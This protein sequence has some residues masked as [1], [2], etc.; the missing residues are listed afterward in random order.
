[1]TRRLGRALAALVV[2][3]SLASCSR[4]GFRSA[5]ASGHP[6]RLVV[7]NGLGDPNS[8]NI[9]LDPG[10]T[11]GDISELTQ[12][13][14]VRYDVHAHPV[15]ELATIVPTQRNHGISADGKTITWHLR[16]G[17]RWSDGAPFSGDDVIFSVHAIM[18]PA[19]NEEQGT[20]GWDLIQKMDEPDPY[21]VVFHLK[22]P[23]GS[24]VPLY[25]GTAANEPCILPK[26][27]LGGLHDINTAPYNSK[28]VGTGPFRVVE[29]RRG[30]A[31]ELEANPY[32][33]RG[34]P[35]L[36]H[37]TFKL[38]SSQETLA[39]QLQTGEVDLWPLMPP[40]YTLRL[41]NVSTLHV[42][43][44]PNFRTTNLDFQ[45]RRPL[46][47]DVRV[48]QAVVRALDRPRL[49][50]TVL[51]GYG[52]MHDG[53]VIP[54]DSP[55]A[56]DPTT[57]FDPASARALLESAGWR[58]QPDGSR[59]KDGQRLVLSFVYPIGTQELIGTIEYLRSALAAVG[60]GIQTKGFDPSHFS[61]QIG[62]GGILY[63]GKY[64]M[65][66]FPRTLEAVS[67]VNGLYSCDTIPPRGENATR[68]CDPRFDELLRDVDLSYDDATR[69]RLFAQAQTR[70]VAD[71]PSIVLYVWRGG[72]AW[73][74]H[75][76]DYDP[77]LLTP[78]D[79]MQDVD[80]R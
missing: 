66:A 78:F 54:L 72:Y 22:R 34:K 2:V 65:D 5:S 77:P 32:S 14:L 75:V 27:V 44:Q 9:H 61:A 57:P 25:F 33:W 3:G 41:Q 64:D 4:A 8:L 76:H 51:H 79:A 43:V 55:A 37:I 69:R 67:D 71:T 6:H 47:A 63:G 56:G 23:Y 15:P 1:M 40:S 53:I 62:A 49:I 11:T 12:A 29:W 16:R 70:F 31:I 20:S 52:T 26:H 39:A 46:V 80:V 45:T 35:K 38:L 13:Y 68:F 60:I 74:R 58:L 36:K 28:P 18:N 19:N 42:F 17:V 73:N 50:A 30:D 59:L 7:A 24:Y 48:R 10:A 21:T